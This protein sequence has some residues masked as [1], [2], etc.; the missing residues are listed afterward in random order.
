M[1]LGVKLIWNR[2][3]YL[4]TR[5]KLTLHNDLGE[6]DWDNL[7]SPTEWSNQFLLVTLTVLG[8]MFK[9]QS[10]PSQAHHVV[11]TLWWW[12]WW[13]WG[14][15]G[16]VVESISEFSL[17]NMKNC[18]GVWEIFSTIKC[19]NNQNIYI[20]YAFWL[21]FLLVNWGLLQCNIIPLHLV[22]FTLTQF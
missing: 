13:W 21:S 2:V 9:R 12:W 8:L 19:N 3:L 1:L 10:V 5:L 22:R 11:L 17:P 6:N 7:S 14:G 20:N 18:A 15:G 16:G 4:V